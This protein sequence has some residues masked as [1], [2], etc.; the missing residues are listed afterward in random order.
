MSHGHKQS[1]SAYGV[2]LD[3]FEKIFNRGIP[4]EGPVD[5]EYLGDITNVS[6]AEQALAWLSDQNNEFEL[7]KR[8]VPA[9]VARA[10]TLVFQGCLQHGVAIPRHLRGYAAR[11]G[12]VQ[13]R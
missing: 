1:T 2:N 7:L 9:D 6:V 11:L 5:I 13:T 12:V 4:F 10:W 8:H 3:F